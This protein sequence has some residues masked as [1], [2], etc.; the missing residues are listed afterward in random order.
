MS[1]V[2]KYFNSSMV[3]APVM[4]NTEGDMYAV[5][6]ACLVDG[7][8]LKAITSISRAGSVATA[9]IPSHGFDPNAVLL[10]AG[11][12]QTE[13]NGEHRITAYDSDHVSFEVTGAP[14]TPGTGSGTAKV[15]PLDFE[16]VYA[17]TYKGVFRSR[18]TLGPRHYL[19]VDNAQPSTEWVTTN[20]R[21]AKIT[22][23]ENMS[24]IDTFVGARVPY[25]PADP[26]RN[27]RGHGWFKWWQAAAGGGDGGSGARKWLVV[28]DDRGF[29]FH[30]ASAASG[31]FSFR[32]MC[33][34][35]E[36]PSYKA[37]DAY[38]GAIWGGEA[39]GGQAV[40]DY[41]VNGAEGVAANYAGSV[42]A[43]S[44]V[45]RDF[46]GLAPT[47]HAL[48]SLTT[49]GSYVSGVSTGLP[50]PN[51][52]DFSMVLHPAYLKDENAALRGYAPGLYV[53]HNDLGTTQVDLTVL[54]N[55]SGYAGKKFLLTVVPY[56][57]SQ[58]SWVALDLTGPWR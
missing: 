45:L 42:Y 30:T 14:A 6:K 49:G 37:S 48:M 29:Y 34:Y 22:L 27:E 2:V 24:D 4:S 36:F 23:A 32:A 53:I 40:G 46:T 51:G 3:G 56:E 9:Y 44:R 17:G 54:E 57:G 55:V 25:N 28:G 41:F 39:Y 38:N 15:A 58:Q 26:T 1:N 19:R 52:P 33:G 43:G 12:S 47:R 20:S 35:L 11:Y 21:Y 50:Y 7:F 5:I 10:I 31:N 18:N 8:N 16:L 13:Y